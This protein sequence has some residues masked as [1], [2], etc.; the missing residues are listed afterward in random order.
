L[1]TAAKPLISV[2]I[3]SY[4][5]AGIIMPYYE[6]ITTTLDSE[7]RFDYE[8]IYV[9]DG[10]SDGSQETLARIASEN[11]KV[12]YIELVRNFGQQRALFAGITQSRGDYVV[13]LDGD[14]Q[15]DPHVVLQLVDAMG[16]RYDLASGIRV[17]R[18]GSWFEKLT[19]AV[20]NIIIRN[21][22]GVIVQDFGSV[23]AFSR[24]LVQK[25]L[26]LKHFYSDVYPAAFLVGPSVIEVPVPHKERFMGSSH[27]DFWMRLRVYIDLYIAY[28]KDEF[29][30]PFKLGA[31]VAIFGVFLL[32]FSFAFKTIL[33]HEAT[34]AQLGMLS[35]LLSLIGVFFAFCSLMMSFLIRV[36][37]Q[38]IW[39][40]PYMIGRTVKNCQVEIA[41]L[42]PVDHSR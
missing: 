23:K 34:Y 21:I 12:T 1:D 15:Y 3:P 11:P 13:T 14:Y 31:F 25:I 24:P 8:L 2:V 30:L 5:D 22:F 28:G 41:D 42:S 37:K 29:Q 40:E 32:F 18:K 38:N 16:D 20:A 4:N 17:G 26:K 7:D 6:A 39:G 19:S 27:W 9:D 33:H 36:Y 10:S 35:T